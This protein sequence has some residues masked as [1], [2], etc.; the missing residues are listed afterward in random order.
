[1]Y[2]EW[3]LFVMLPMLDG[4]AIFLVNSYNN[5]IECKAAVRVYEAYNTVAMCEKVKHKLVPM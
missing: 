2:F 5:A 3:V 1:M 4:N